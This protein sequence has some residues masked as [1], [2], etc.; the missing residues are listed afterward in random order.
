MKELEFMY[1]FSNELKIS[2]EQD[3]KDNYFVVRCGSALTCCDDLVEVK[4]ALYKYDHFN[5]ING[6]EI[7]MVMKLLKWRYE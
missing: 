2:I 5:M 6:N 7:A 4:E 1:T 3:M